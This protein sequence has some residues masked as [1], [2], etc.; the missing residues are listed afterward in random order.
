MR[1]LGLSICVHLCSSMV[2]YS[3]PATQPATTRPALSKG[4][5]LFSDGKDA[6]FRRDFPRAIDLFRK[7]AAEDKTKTSYRVHLARA[8]QYANQGKEAEALLA[9]ILKANP[10]HVEA[11]Q[12]LGD[13]YA[14][15]ENWKGL[16][17]LLEPLLKYRH[18]YPR[19]HLL[20][21]AA[22][23]L[24]DNDK[25]RKYYEEAVKLNPQSAGDFYSLGN[26]Y[27]GGNFFALAAD[28]YQQAIRLGV[29]SP[30]LHYKL[31]TAYFNLRNY[32]GNVTNA[33]V[34]SGKPGTING[35]WYIIEGVPGQKDVWRVAPSNSA[36]YQIARA[37]ADG[38]EDRPDIQFLRANIYLNA[39]RF[40]QAYEM[41]GAL[42][43]SIPREDK[44]L[45]FYYYAQ[46]AFGAGEYEKYL[47]LLGEAIKLNK[48]AYGP[49]LVEAIVRVA[50]QYNQSGELDK[51]IDYLVKAVTESPQTA[52]LHLKLGNAYEEATKLSEAAVQWQMVL[53]LEPDHPKRLELLNQINKTRHPTTRPASPAR[54]G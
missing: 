48:E 5:E 18:D 24:A 39:G 34:K 37:I 40:A 6:L 49:T 38:I 36:I 50:E 17:A 32:F 10:D 46:A 2:S 8:L 7:A 20:A 19:Y 43:K 26:I 28:A 25:A 22:Y 13:I 35:D 1:I 11:G 44:A 42:E 31:G 3:A 30:L 27:L 47:S 45:F 12:L 51:Y 15:Q 52:A 9:E 41:Y 54:N 53:D 21:E 16:L 23:N 33:S 14:R 29:Q 4:D